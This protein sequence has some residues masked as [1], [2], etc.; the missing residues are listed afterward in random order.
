MT[1][2]ILCISSEG[3]GNAILYVPVVKTLGQS[4][5]GCAIDICVSS[6]AAAEVFGGL[7]SVR[8]II[9]LN[10]RTSNTVQLVKTVCRLRCE[11]YDLIITSYLDKGIKV[12][13]FVSLIGAKKSVG[14]RNGWWSW[15]YTQ[16]V[17]VPQLS[18]EVSMNLLL[19]DALGA[20][21]RL[22]DTTISVEQA[23]RDRASLFIAEKLPASPRF[24]GIHPGSGINLGRRSKRWPADRFAGLIQQVHEQLKMRCVVFGG[25]DETELVS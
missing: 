17:P 15:L 24:I 25:P 11:H 2:K 7:P 1:M 12:A 4:Y 9:T 3:I 13:L 8:N 10:K 6:T 19:T 14:F 16:A 21:T 20:D 5:P 18:H 23:H 22:T